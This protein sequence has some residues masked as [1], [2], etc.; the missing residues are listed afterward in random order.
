MYEWT[1]GNLVISVFVF[2]GLGRFYCLTNC[3]SICLTVHLSVRLTVHHIDF[4][5]HVLTQPLKQLSFVKIH[6]LNHSLEITNALSF[7]C[8]HDN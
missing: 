7:S 1:R 3:P 4:I 8:S 2:T 5:I 6:G